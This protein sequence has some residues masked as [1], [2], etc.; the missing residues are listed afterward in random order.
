MRC[1]TARGGATLCSTRS[2]ERGYGLELDP[3]YVDAAVRRW[4]AFTKRD[5][6]LAGTNT[7]FEDGCALRNETGQAQMSTREP[8]DRSSSQGRTAPKRVAREVGYGRPPQAHR[9]KPGQSGN[10]RGRPKGAKNEA[11][12]LRDLLNRKIDV[13]EGGRVRKI[14]LRSHTAAVHRRRV[15]GQHQER[16]LPVQSLCG[17]PGGRTRNQAAVDRVPHRRKDDRDDR[18]RLLCRND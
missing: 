2:W 10:P 16:R 5:A 17:N 1:A 14:T 13:R 15:E 11:T 7:T 9:F 3:L 6:L 12:I 8:R 4:Q 18:C